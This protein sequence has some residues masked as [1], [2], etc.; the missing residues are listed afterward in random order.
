MSTKAFQLE[1]DAEGIATLRFDLPGEK[2]NKFTVAV[3]E[4]LERNLDQ[5]SGRK[6][7][8]ALVIRSGKEDVFI[9]GADL[10]MFQ[11]VFNDPQKA[12]KIMDLGHR[13]FNKLQQLPFPTIALINGA[14][15]GG[16]LEFALACTYRVATDNPK[17]SIGL[18]EVT[19]GI[20]PGWGGTQR[21]PRLVG[22]EKGVEM[23]VTGRSVDG[24]KAWKTK[25]ADALVPWQ[26][27]DLRLKDFLK[28][29]LDKAGQK[30]VLEKRKRSGARALLLEKNP[31]GRAFLFSQTKKTILEKTKGH[32]PAPL[33]SLG[34][35]QR[36][37]RFAIKRRLGKR[38]ACLFE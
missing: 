25:L 26:F 21:L 8:K 11:G 35:D 38:E 12:Q 4:E 19:L 2:V 23:I 5:L 31:L 33:F 18:P 36:N 16:G 10:H 3:L 29:I 34:S 37:L 27:Q 28:T 7:I 24:M 20:M 13:T 9:A 1:V 6:D 14:C 15:V 17:T 22:L 30:K 32:Y